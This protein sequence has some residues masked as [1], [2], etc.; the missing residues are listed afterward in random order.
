MNYKHKLA[1]VLVCLAMMTSFVACDNG[2]QTSSGSNTSSETTSTVSE[3]ISSDTSS[4]ESEESGSIGDK[5]ELDQ[6]IK[7]KIDDAVKINSDVVGWLNIAGTNID[8]PVLQ[9]PDGKN[10]PISQVNQYYVGR[11]L[12]KKVSKNA[13]IFAD[14]YNQ[15]GDRTELS[16]NTILYGHNWTNIEKNGAAVRM[17]D[18]RDVM[19]GQLLMFSDLDFAKKTPAF[20][21]ATLDDNITWVV[22]AAFYTDTS[23]YYIEDA[24]TDSEF[25]KIV[26]GAI[27]RS[28]H[29]YDVDVRLSDKILTLSTCTR[30]LGSTDDQR[31]VVMA[32]ILRDN[33]KVED[34]AAPTD[35]PNPKRPSWYKGNR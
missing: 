28:E 32:R 15:M 18:D 7:K 16:R 25:M 31:F 20:T 1:A 19:F 3:D 22:F 23:F 12:Y 27:E 9:N 11:D 6:D 33:E 5:E 4:E 8:Y 2:G 13:C 17:N 24:P 34:F 10:V 26:N 21:F 14:D 29:I 30:R 35:N